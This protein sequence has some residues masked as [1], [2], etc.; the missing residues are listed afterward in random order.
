MRQ[1]D[2]EH[3]GSLILGEGREIGG[4][5][6]AFRILFRCRKDG[7]DYLGQ[8]RVCGQPE[9]VRCEMFNE[10]YF[11]G[12]ASGRSAA[13]TALADAIL[14]ILVDHEG[15]PEPHRSRVR[16]LA[17]RSV[18]AVEPETP[19]IADGEAVELRQIFDRLN[20]EYFGGAVSAEICWGRNTRGRNQ[21]SFRFGSYDYRKKLIRI[22]PRL[23]AEFVPRAVVELTVFHEMCHQLLPP[24]RKRGGKSI[25]HHP[26]FKKKERE[27][28]HYREARAWEKL[29]WKTLLSPR[30]GA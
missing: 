26:D 28:A 24:V 20:G 30:E 17:G 18:P 9:A 4:D 27:Y 6:P 21:W 12:F 2:G 11:T 13:E 8:V 25:I 16:R 1:K 7:V 29:N 19:L 10:Q 3:A 5:D 23:R 14:K 22:H 15:I